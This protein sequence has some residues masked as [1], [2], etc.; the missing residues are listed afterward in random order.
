[1][2]KTCVNYPFSPGGLVCWSALKKR[3]A[4]E[5]VAIAMQ[6]HS[7]DANDLL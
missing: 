1:M 3:Y 7:A 5:A 2:V 4:A 6:V